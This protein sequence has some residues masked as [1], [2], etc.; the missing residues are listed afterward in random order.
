MERRLKKTLS[1]IIPRPIWNKLREMQI[2]RRHARVAAE[3]KSLIDSYYENFGPEA[4]LP[5][6]AKKTFETQRIIWQYWAQGYDSAPDV[7]RQCYAS[8][9]KWADG[10]T[11]IRLDD[12]N[13]QDYITLPEFITDKLQYMSRAYFSDLLR[14]CILS[15]YGGLW[16]DAT[17]FL[18]GMIPEYIYEG[19]FFLY[20]RDVEEKNKDYWKNVYAYYFGWGKGF[21]VNMLSSILYASKDSEVIRGLCGIMLYHWYKGSTSIP[22]YFFLQILF[23]VLIKEHFPDRNCRIVSDCKPHYLQQLINDPDFTLATKEEIL[24]SISLH[25]LTY[26]QHA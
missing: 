13:I 17:V 19:D 22:D 24:N 9:D 25:K 5:L 6:K 11:I 4:S 3:C 21:R 10:F 1:A 18:S 8:V 23:D 20:Q 7:V 16:L 14:L 15:Q 26:K 12:N 2:E